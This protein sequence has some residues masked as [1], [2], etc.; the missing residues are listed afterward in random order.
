MAKNN[1]K[2]PLFTIDIL[3]DKFTDYLRDQ[4]FT[5]DSIVKYKGVHVFF[6]S[7]F[8]GQVMK[9]QEKN[10][11]DLVPKLLFTK[12]FSDIYKDRNGNV[13]KVLTGWDI[14]NNIITGID[15]GLFKNKMLSKKTKTESNYQSYANK[16][17]KFIKTIYGNR[18]SKY[19]ITKLTKVY[20]IPK[21]SAADLAV[22]R[23]EDGEIY[24]NNKLRTKFKSRLRCQDRTSGDKIWLPLRFIGKIY[25]A[26]KK[27]YEKKNPGKKKKNKFSEWL[28]DLVGSINIHYDDNNGKV[29]HLT[30]NDG[31]S[32][33]LKPL[34]RGSKVHDVIIFDSNGSHYTVLTPTGKGNKKE[35]MKVRDISEIAID[36]VKSIDRILRDLSDEVHNYQNNQLVQ[37]MKVSEKYKAIQTEEEPDED[38]A[39]NELLKPG[40]Y[41]INLTKLTKELDLIKNDGL[42]RLMASKYNS[43]KSN[44]ETF[45]DIFERGNKTYYGII[46]TGIKQA[47]SKDNKEMTLY[48][49]LNNNYPTGSLLIDFSDS[50]QL[51][52]ENINKI[53]GFKLEDIINRI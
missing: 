50:K 28:D 42:L 4:N 23:G 13:I 46:E 44:G 6:D 2:K 26:D 22:L 39:V 27:A 18:N 3:L 12:S 35:C 40:K 52:G 36:H 11:M 48:Q 29:E 31:V 30:I 47:N 14:I 10:F 17:F 7:N 9:G 25:S 43:Q 20:N 1:S 34:K 19:H 16:F 33:W 49:E 8:R 45:Q 53:E 21:L 5:E 37:L 15:N 38:K 41:K 32:L 24:L 51:R